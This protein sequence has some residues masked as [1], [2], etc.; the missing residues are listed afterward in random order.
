MFLS[1]SLLLL[2]PRELDG[3]RAM[4]ML[5]NTAARSFL[6]GC[7]IPTRL[8]PYDFIGML[9]FAPHAKLLP[10]KFRTRYTVEKDLNDRR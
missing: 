7:P 2:I 8:F 5:Y 6:W 3:A 4:Q 1:M 9:S 10:H